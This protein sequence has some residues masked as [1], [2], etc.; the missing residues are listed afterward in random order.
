M[1][2][3]RH[4]CVELMDEVQFIPN[5]YDLV[6]GTSGFQ[7]V[8]GPNMGGKSTYIRGWFGPVASTSSIHFV[9]VFFVF[10]SCVVSIFYV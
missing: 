1:Q 4:P 8:T 9:F 7:I 6:R 2:E 10:L 3:A 5:D